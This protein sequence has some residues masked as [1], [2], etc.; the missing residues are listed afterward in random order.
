MSYTPLAPCIFIKAYAGALAGMAMSQYISDGTIADSNTVAAYAGAWA[1][2][3]D[4]AWGGVRAVSDLDESATF[5]GSFGAWKDRGVGQANGGLPAATIVSFAAEVA[6]IISVITAAE[7]FYTANGISPNCAGDTEGITQ[8][9]QDVLAGP[10]SG[11]QAA[12]VVAVSGNIAGVLNIGKS[13]NTSLTT[14]NIDGEGLEAV[15]IGISSVPGTVITLGNGASDIILVGPT[16]C[17]SILQLGTNPAQ[18][19][20]LRMAN[21]AEISFRN[22]G[23]TADVAALTVD[24][25]NSIQVGGTNA[26]AAYFNLAG[27][28]LF[29]V[30]GAG[31]YAAHTGAISVAAS[32]VLLNTEYNLPTI[33]IT[34]TVDAASTLT[35]PNLAGLWFLDTTGVTFGPEGALTLASGSATLIVGTEDTPPPTLIVVRTTGANQISASNIG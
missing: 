3:F 15:N 17:E 23:N 1:E 19:G 10:G 8:L 14:V 7:N 29:G 4:T 25:T 31:L 18:T 11:S 30:A 12:T 16:T 27:A 34:G 6:A 32:H 33:Q 2:Q 5:S 22:A 35:F 21:A 26:V 9:T 13:T 28:Q 24:N 20:E